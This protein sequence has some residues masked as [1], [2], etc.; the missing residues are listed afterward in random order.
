M[1]FNLVSFLTIGMCLFFTIVILFP[2]EKTSANY[3]MLQTPCFPNISYPGMGAALCSFYHPA[4]HKYCSVNIATDGNCFFNSVALALRQTGVAHTS[5]IRLRNIVAN[6]IC[7]L[8]DAEAEETRKQWRELLQQAIVYRNGEMIAEFGHAFPLLADPD[9]K[10]VQTVMR[11]KRNMLT[12]K[13]WGEEFAIQT[14]EDRFQVPFNVLNLSC[15]KQRSFSKNS[16]VSGGILLVLY[17]NHYVPLFEK[18]V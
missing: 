4:C 16:E 17:G 15:E 18:T 1:K 10:Q 3:L 6:R 11:L 2:K 9:M 14:L 5:A 7:S 13:Y 8:G 12:S